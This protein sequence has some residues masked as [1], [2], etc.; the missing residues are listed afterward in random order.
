MQKDV[1]GKAC[2]EFY[3]SEDDSLEIEVF[4]DLAGDEQIPVSY[5]FREYEEMPDLEK[6]ALELAKGKILDIGACVGVH[7]L[8]LQEK[9]QDVTA[10]EKST[11]CCNLMEERGVLKIIE[12]DFYQY[13]SDKYDT[14]LLL[15]NGVGLAGKLENIDKF[16]LHCR[17]LLKEKGKILMDSSDIIYMFEDEDGSYVIDLNDEYYGNMNYTIAFEQEKQNFDWLYKDACQ[18]CG[19]TAK[20]ILDGEHYDYLAEIRVD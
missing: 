19:M 11:I 3:L 15:M 16:L 6:K 9:G 12:Q 4:S 13:Q 7:S 18:R 17:S 20:K 5:L 14:I 2:N 10:L 1:F 8:V